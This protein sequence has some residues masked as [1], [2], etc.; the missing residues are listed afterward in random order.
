M[1]LIVIFAEKQLTIRCTVQFLDVTGDE[2]QNMQY[3]RSAVWNLCGIESRFEDVT[4]DEFA[5]KV[6]VHSEWQW[7]IVHI[8]TIGS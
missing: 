4:G 2:F 6:A 7:E 3:V 1:L 8:R 5:L